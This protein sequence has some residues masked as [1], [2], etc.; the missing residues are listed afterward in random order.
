MKIKLCLKLAVLLVAVVFVLN[1]FAQQVPFANVGFDNA[2]IPEPIPPPAAVRD[3]FQLDPYYQQWINIRGF[4]VL[5]SAE[6]SPYTVKEAAWLIYQMIGHRPDVLT[7]MAAR[8][9]RFAIVPHNKHTS[10]M[11]ES[12]TGRLSFFWDVRHRAVHCRGCPIASNTEEGLIGKSAS[13]IH[14]FGHLLQDWG[15]NGSDSTFNARVIRL[16][17]MAKAE[18]L[19]KERYAGSDQA[20]YWAEG[21]ASWFH[22]T[23]ANQHVAL[24]RSAL[25]QYDPRLA[26]LLMEV[27]G[28]RS[29]RYTRPAT[30]THLPH[31]QGF[32]PQEAPVYQ[33]PARLLELERQLMDPNSDGGGK[34]VNL[35]L[36]PPSELRRLSALTAIEDRTDFIFGNLTGN[37]LAL[38]YFDADGKKSIGYYSTTDDFMALDTHV[39]AIWLIEDH[40]GKDFA[41]FRAEEEVGRVLIGGPPNREV[42]D[43]NS[44]GIVKSMDGASTAREEHLD[45]NSDGIVN[46]LDLTPIASRYGRRGVNPADIN[47]DRIVN[48]FDMLWVAAS[49][50]SLPQQVVKTFKARQVERW[51]NDARQLGIEV[52]NLRKGIVVLEHL[53][54][55]I[56]LSPK[57]TKVAK[58]A[59]RTIFHGHTDLVWSVAFSPNGRIL[60]SGSWDNTI[61]LWNLR[62]RELKTTLI[63]HTGEVMSV[64]FSPDGR[65]LASGSWDNTIRLWD[66]HNGALKQTFS[67]HTDGITAV[68]FSPDGAMLASSSADRTIRFW[69]VPT[70]RHQKTITAQARIQSITFSP[71]GRTLASGSSE[72]SIGLWHVNTG[73][74]K[75]NITKKAG[76]VNSV[77]FSPNGSILASG[78]GGGNNTI[79]LWHANTGKLK[80]NITKHQDTVMSVVFSPDGQ[81]LASGSW[82]DTIGLW[83]PN[84][85]EEKKRLAGH[86]GSVNAVVFSADGRLLASSTD[87]IIRLWNI[88][89]LLSKDQNVAPA[90]PQHPQTVLLETTHLL[91]NYPNP[92]NPETWIPY[93]L[94]E[95]SEVSIRIYD[96]TGAVVRKLQLGH[97]RAGFY[98]SRSRAA[99]WDGR[100]NIGEP[101]ASGVYFYTLSAGDFTATRKLL[102]RK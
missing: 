86:R 11:P 38:Y 97:Q 36:H 42:L 81:T 40:T 74:L 14:E 33:R 21:V 66:S 87:N 52:E 50:S 94:A 49:V 22:D 67:G 47:K 62:A 30:R 68:V 17:N 32:N 29:W 53:L 63:G 46:L 85:G 37:D 10:D 65:T 73:K 51:L 56:N 83:N 26:Q 78:S 59:L 4:P 99:Y 23:N 28:D 89:M 60:A 18:G 55:E 5:A 20:E 25:K 16:Y 100:N 9:A 24:T 93:Q 34:W 90:A 82:D 88:E 13:P 43:V 35:K 92:F 54:R 102:I 70:R 64:A 80:K 61:R 76:W 77:A 12:N 8:T 27:F 95:D 1:S 101:V 71:N 6:V 19:Y 84:T 58:G 7:R 2:N 44:D 75:K 98:Q 96:T 48:I 91:R 3:F 39:G 79:G 72:G 45:V 31:L 69:D 57:S 41:V 15:L